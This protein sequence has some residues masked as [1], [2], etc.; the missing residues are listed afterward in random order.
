MAFFKCDQ[1]SYSSQSSVNLYSHKRSHKSNK[2]RAPK[3]PLFGC[4]ECPFIGTSSGALQKHMKR[5]HT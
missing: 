5:S 1:C 3:N 2:K 4:K